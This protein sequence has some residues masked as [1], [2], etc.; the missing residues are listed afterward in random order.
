MGVLV[1]SW[2]LVLRVLLFFEDGGTAS[3]F[4]IMEGEDGL[5]GIVSQMET[6]DLY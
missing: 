5:S 1:P 4:K 3:F 6:A 2:T